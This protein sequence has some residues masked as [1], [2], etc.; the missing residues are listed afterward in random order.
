MFRVVALRLFLVA[1]AAGGV[2]SDRNIASVVAQQPITPGEKTTI[3]NQPLLPDGGLDFVRAVNQFGMR[4]TP[5]QR[6]GIVPLLETLSADDFYDPGSYAA[7]RGELGLTDPGTASTP[8]HRPDEAM[9]T[10]LQQAV[11][12]V[13]TSQ[14]NTELANWLANNEQALDKIDEAVARGGWFYPLIDAHT[15]LPS[16]ERLSGIYYASLDVLT[17][18]REMVAALA[19][20]SL[21]H[22][23]EGQPDKGLRDLVRI[24]GLVGLL[25]TGDFNLDILLAAW[26]DDHAR[27]VVQALLNSNALRPADYSALY[28]AMQKLPTFDPDLGALTMRDMIVSIECLDGVARGRLSELVFYLRTTNG[29]IT[30]PDDPNHYGWMKN[31]G[32]RDWD[33][34]ARDLRQ[35]FTEITQAMRADTFAER[36]RRLNLHQTA[37]TEELSAK[38]GSPLHQ[39]MKSGQATDS[40]RGKGINLLLLSFL[41]QS[42]N[43]SVNAVAKIQM[44]RQVA[45][46]ALLVEAFRQRSGRLPDSLDELTPKL[47]RT[48]P[49]DVFSS[50]P[51]RYQKSDGGFKLYS[52]G[53]NSKD[54][55]GPNPRT[56][57]HDNFGI[58]VN[59]GI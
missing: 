54:L 15:T 40:D 3:W 21:M 51:L 38:A 34:V 47:L 56:P 12:A 13:W 44:S 42:T 45:L 46:T 18:I 37:F 29:L 4:R 41:F 52:V 5:P 23:G 27:E 59:K 32:I 9:L 8:F 31:L 30:I 39:R 2:G 10:T 49:T 57:R 43:G 14:Q 28:Q 6:N 16:G 58:V 50:Q 22:Y 7:L 24:H 33:R 35:S 53:A 20:R 17:V 11:N 26:I 19:A 25:S 1:I 48:V 36:R 55:G